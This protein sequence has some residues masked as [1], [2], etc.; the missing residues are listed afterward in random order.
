[1]ESRCQP[2]F[3]FSA[4]FTSNSRPPANIQQ[5]IPV[6]NDA[7]TWNLA[8]LS[9]L[10]RDYQISIGNF[11]WILKREIYAAWYQ[12]DWKITPRLTANLGVRY[13][14]DHGAQGE[15]VEFQPWLSGRRPTDK[16]N[17]A[18]RAG[19]AFQATQRTVFRGG[20]GLFFTELE[21]DGL[22]QSY[23][24]TQHILMT[25][26]NDGRPVPSIERLVDLI[27]TKKPGDRIDLEVVRGTSRIHLNVELGRQP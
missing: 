19:F 11:A 13:D 14:L 2:G 16:N 21:D 12:D 24:Q 3:S 1:M 15:W 6:W 4:S 22:H 10:M 18:P 27:A 20:Y 26:P 25:I 8:A 9:P 17:L 5:L 23:L 7:S